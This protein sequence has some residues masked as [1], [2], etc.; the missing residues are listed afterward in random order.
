MVTFL[1][2]GLWHG[3]N[4][5]FVVW[6]GLNGLYQIIDKLF[7]SVK[8]KIWKKLSS[9]EKGK[10]KIVVNIIITFI[11]ISFTWI[12]FRANSMDEAFLVIKKIYQFEGRLFTAKIG[13][14]VI[15]LVILIISDILQ[16]RN[17]GVHYF[18]DNKHRAVRYITYLTLVLII[19]MIGVFDGAQF[20]YFQF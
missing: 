12:F 14:G 7:T 9:S 16:E 17:S 1:V 3:A 10:F 18:L 6:G 5:T 20:I 13:Y 19:L 11:L 4:W 15:L 2:S 8:G